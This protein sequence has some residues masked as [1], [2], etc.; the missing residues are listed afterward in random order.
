[1]R[2]VLGF[3]P[4]R[5]SNR[6]SSLEGYPK[7]EE[8][9]ANHPQNK[10][11][12]GAA[13][14]ELFH[15]AKDK[16]HS[17]E[18]RNSA[19]PTRKRT[20]KDSPR[21]APVQPATLEIGMESP[22]IVF[23]GPPGQS[24]GALLSG[25]LILTPHEPEISIKTLEMVLQAKVTT[26]R[27]VKHDCPECVTKTTELFR[28]KFLSEPTHFRQRK[29][30]FPFSYLLPGHIPATSHGFMGVI[31]YLL[32]A[33]AITNFSEPVNVTRYLKVQRALMPGLDKNST[34]VFPPTNLVASVILPSVVHPM[35][36][37]PVQLRLAGVVT[38]SNDGQVRWR[39]RRMNWRVDETSKM[40]SEACKKHAAKVG[41][42][43]KGVLHE[44][45]VDLGRDDIKRGWKTDF[46]T[47]GGLIE[48]E[49]NAGIRPGSNP[50]CDVESPSGYSVHHN[51][52]VEIIV[53][54]E[55]QL[56][57]CHKNP[58]PTGSARVLR[59][60]FKLVVTE[61]AG[62]GISWDE[63]QPPMYE[64]VPGSPPGYAKMSDYEGEAL[65]EEP[66][67]GFH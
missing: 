5:R 59:M 45:T 4:T 63:E 34:R 30:H 9:C 36:E 44:D 33:E 54:Q 22:P 23:Y 10:Q 46:D 35:G 26:K 49:F 55:H 16:R 17:V 21:L 24:T 41:G 66:L 47:E 58:V 20:S 6:T 31:D 56:Y 11:P 37:F 57:K 1:M 42:E 50:L 62:L 12:A 53:A 27:P 3:R 65:P 61:R 32:S 51:L 25:Q 8:D 43:G 52:S 2:S 38:K 40:I 60:Q 29:H 7:V 14:M 48:V 19:S 67:E 64:D 15:H 18:V 28:W 39:I 13:V